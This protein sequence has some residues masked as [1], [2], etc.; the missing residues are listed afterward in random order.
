MASTISRIDEIIRK[1]NHTPVVFRGTED[2]K[3]FGFGDC[4]A[5][6]KVRSINGKNY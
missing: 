4:S 2:C 3:A 5:Q 6:S 1:G